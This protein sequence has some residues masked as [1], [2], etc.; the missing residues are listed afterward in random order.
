MQK[1]NEQSIVI[2]PASLLLN[3]QDEL[4]KFDCNLKYLC[5]YG[6]AAERKEQI[7]NIKD[8]DLI[9]TT[10][11]YLKK[12]IDLYEKTNFSNIILDEAQ[13]IKNHA[14]KTAKEVKN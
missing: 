4:D 6:N 11:D 14:T 13:Y 5:V 10:Y 7:A 12:D 8:Y 9:I 1:E 3:W 2:C